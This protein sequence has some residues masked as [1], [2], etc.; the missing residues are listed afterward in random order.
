MIQINSGLHSSEKDHNA[1]TGWTLK[2]DKTISSSEAITLYQY[3]IKL[4]SNGEW[5]DMNEFHKWMH[6]NEHL[7]AYSRDTGSVRSSLS[8]LIP[9]FDGKY[10]LD[11]S[12][13]KL[14]DTLYGFRLI[15]L[16][17]FSLEILQQAIKSSIKRALEYLEGIQN[18]SK[19]D[20]TCYLKIPFAK[21]EQCWQYTFHSVVEAKHSLETVHINTLDISEETLQTKNQSILSCDLRLLKPKQI[22]KDGMLM[23]SPDFSYMISQKIESGLKEKFPESIKYIGTFGCMTGMYL[24]TSLQ[25]IENKE[26]LKNIHRE[27][28]NILGWIKKDTLVSH[29]KEQ[30]NWILSNY[31]KYGEK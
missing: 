31:E 19:W 25:D 7:L 29:E 3:T 24:I 11:V 13:F 18:G 12:P 16:E 1:M 22:G 27:V 2:V 9:W 21:A 10:I 20:E 15:S 8:E 17:K 26:E 4:F 6:T 5:Q 28:M 23:L 14:S 30:L